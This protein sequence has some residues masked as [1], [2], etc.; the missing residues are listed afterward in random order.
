MS[1]FTVINWINKGKIRTICTVGGQRRIPVDEAQAIVERMKT[2]TTSRRGKGP[3][4]LFAV[5]AN[6]GQ[7]MRGFRKY[8]KNK[9][10]LKA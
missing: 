8:F 1:R 7:S 4:F 5:G 2:G 9:K 6:I 3:D 10:D